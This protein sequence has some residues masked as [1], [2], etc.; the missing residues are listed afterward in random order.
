M[1]DL[2]IYD[3]DG[4]YGKPQ[5]VHCASKKVDKFFKLALKYF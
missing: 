4:K 3:N 2:H 5:S 1:H